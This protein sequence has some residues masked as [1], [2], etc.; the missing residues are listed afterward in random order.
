MFVYVNCENKKNLTHY[1]KWNAFPEVEV[2]VERTGQDRTLSIYTEQ[3]ICPCINSLTVISF[4]LSGLSS[5]GALK[6]RPVIH[7]VEDMPPPS[8]LWS[9]QLVTKKGEGS[10]RYSWKTFDQAPGDCPLCTCNPAAICGGPHG[11]LWFKKSLG[12]S[13]FLSQQEKLS[14]YHNVTHTVP[15]DCPLS[16]HLTY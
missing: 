3:V 1:S 8:H 14:W 5:W 2:E 9:L 13:Y 15:L 4:P 12:E 6:L 7:A 16:L 10:F 11:R